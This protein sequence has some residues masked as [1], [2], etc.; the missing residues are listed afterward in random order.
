MKRYIYIIIGIIVV[1]AVAIALIFY[2]KNGSSSGSLFGF[3]SIGSLPQTGTQGTGA[4]QQG[5]SGQ[6]SST[7]GSTNSSSS[8]TAAQGNLVQTFG[9][10]A[11]GPVLDYFVDAQNTIT[12][13]KPDGTV[14]SIAAGKTTTISSTTTIN[15]IIT[16]SFSYD[17]KKVLVSSGDPANPQANI[18]TVATAAWVSAPQGMQS[19]KWSPSNYQI[20]YLA[21]STSG[22]LSLATIDASNLKKASVPLFSLH[23]TDL[24]LQWIGKTQFMLSDKPTMNAKES[25]WLYDSQKGTLTPMAYE[26]AGLESTW[27][28]TASGTLGLVFQSTG[29]SSSLK[30]TTI[31]GTTYH[32]LTFLTLPSKCVFATETAVPATSSSTTQSSTKATSKTTP[33]PVV[34]SYVYC[35]IPSDSSALSSVQLPDD[36]NMMAAF[37]SD[38]IAR[39]NTQTGGEDILWNGSAQNIDSS[40][41]KFFN[42]T[43]FFI[44]RYDQKL[45]ALTLI[46]PTQ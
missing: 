21:Q 14:I 16:A 25:A 44:N 10:V 40:D 33:S 19:P 4:G 30:L 2:F 23:A 28:A 22:M 8:N 3:G 37:T 36:Y 39:V 26:A 32:A 18:F 6:N 29:K 20:A 11:D 13:I 12:A 1:A 42:N 41:V 24:T 9:I 5:E 7:T 15:N 45:Y 43:L 34:S 35:G 46:P 31:T 38:L 17:G 27:G